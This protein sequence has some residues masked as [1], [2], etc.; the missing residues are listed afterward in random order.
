MCAIPGAVHSMTSANG[1][2]VT[3]LAIWNV[4]ITVSWLRISG[5][6]ASSYTTVGLAA[7][8]VLIVLAAVVT[9]RQ[10]DAGRG[11]ALG[12]AAWVAAAGYVLAWY[13]VLGFLVAALRPTERIAR[14]LALQGGVITAAYLV[15]RASLDRAGIIGPVVHVYVPIA[16]TAGFVWALMER[17]TSPIPTA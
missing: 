1:G 5:L 4:P 7:V 6:H 17:R 11:A 16:L 9:R 8:A 10:P 15:P 13:T 14:W 3:R 2:V 12:G